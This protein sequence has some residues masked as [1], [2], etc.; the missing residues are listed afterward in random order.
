M[1]VLNTLGATA[2]AS[3]TL[4][5]SPLHASKHSKTTFTS[6]KFVYFN[7]LLSS[8]LD[9]VLCISIFAFISAALSPMRLR[10]EALGSSEAM[11]FCIVV[12]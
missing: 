4:P 3:G 5:E 11:A 12:L 6:I 10:N 9:F 1:G 7:S 8:V 2:A